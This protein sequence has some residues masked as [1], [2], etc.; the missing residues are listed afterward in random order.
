LLETHIVTESGPRQRMLRGHSE[1]VGECNVI[2][3]L[4]KS[5]T[6]RGLT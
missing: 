4:E 3:G 5:F 6:L 2:P 1:G